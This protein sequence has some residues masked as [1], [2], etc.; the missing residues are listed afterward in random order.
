MKNRLFLYVQE[1]VH[2]LVWFI[3]H[4]EGRYKVDEIDFIRP[5]VKD[6]DICLDVGAQAGDWTKPRSRLVPRGR[7]YAFEALPLTLWI[8]S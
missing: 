3:R 4:V 8:Y 5:Y 1:V 6:G 2:A 7:V